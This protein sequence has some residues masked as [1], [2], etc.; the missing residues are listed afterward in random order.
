M[1]GAMANTSDKQDTIN[2]HILEFRYKPNPKVLDNRGVWA[3]VLSEEMELT[4]W[5]IVD[6]R[7]DVFSPNEDQKV[8]VSFR[9]A[10]FVV[11]DSPLPDYFPNK[12][13]KVLRCLFK[14][15]G[16]GNNIAIERIGVRSR[17]CVPFAGEF[18]TLTELYESRFLTL[19]QRAKTKLGEGCQ[20]IDIGGPLN[21]A[22]NAGNFN[23]MSGPM[24]RA[25]LIDFFKR[26]TGF[27]DVGLF[28]DIDYWKKPGCQMS[29][30]EIVGTV[31]NLAAAA[32]TRYEQIRDTVLGE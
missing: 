10:G 28:I 8:F 17:F 6:N 7:I 9:N 4:E 18:K 13:V 22:D 27:P 31:K 14:F 30:N 29:E 32:W 5:R 23:T 11:N 1:V 20:L 24:A 15:E 26:E 19:T 3:E 12:A 16:F 2:E 25:Q 21:F